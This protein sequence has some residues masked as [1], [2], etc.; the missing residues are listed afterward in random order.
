MEFT[1]VQNG[2][3]SIKKAHLCIQNLDDLIEGIDH[4]LKDAIIF[5][6]HGIEILF[7]VMLAKRSTALMFTN[8]KDYQKAKENLK[9]SNKKD[10]FEIDPNLQTVSL[11]E[12]LT[13]IEY[14]CDV[15]IEESM[16]SAIFELNMIRNKLMHFS[17]NLEWDEAEKLIFT[18][19][20][21]YTVVC[22]FFESHIE[23]FNSYIDSARYEYTV[24]EYYNDERVAEEMYEEDRF[25]LLDYD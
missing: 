9:K 23:N 4:N 12:A 16:K 11:K 1:L 22:N 20:F 17:I 10:V 8:I 18:L 15:E 24:E 5:L 13:R 25:G 19:Q 21:C 14:L 7:K 6:N 2:A 3:D